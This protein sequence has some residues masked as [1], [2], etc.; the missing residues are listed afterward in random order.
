MLQFA[1][2]IP[3]RGDEPGVAGNGRFWTAAGLGGPLFQ[4]A[5]SQYELGK[6]DK[7]AGTLA[8]AAH[9][10]GAPLLWQRPLRGKRI[11]FRKRAEHHH[12][13]SSWAGGDR[14]R[15]KLSR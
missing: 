15:N 3:G 8:A 14:G 9:W 7:W 2:P 5:K 6:I 11:G 13:D 10:A 1:A 4:K 12:K